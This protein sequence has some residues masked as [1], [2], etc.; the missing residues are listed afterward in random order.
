MLTN[1]VSFNQTRLR[2]LLFWVTGFIAIAVI[3]GAL[4][5]DLTG[6]SAA[7]RFMVAR[8]GFRGLRLYLWFEAGVLVTIVAAIGWSAITT[9]L[10]IARGDAVALSGSDA[11]LRPRMPTPL[12]YLLVLLGSALTALA[13]TTLVLFNSCRYMRIV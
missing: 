1:S 8:W 4:T 11:S 5:I 7:D 12:G 9:G 13:I 6:F 2:L 3:G 10:D